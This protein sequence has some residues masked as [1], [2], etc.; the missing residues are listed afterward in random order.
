MKHT[1]TSLHEAA[2]SNDWPAG[3]PQL[4]R[5][6]LGLVLIGLVRLYQ[7]TLSPIV[8]VL[9]AQCRYYPSCSQYMVLAIRKHGPLRGTLKGMGRVCRCHPWSAGGFDWP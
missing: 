6:G 9:G 7:F 4:L 8:N 5:Q 1:V 2:A 3:R